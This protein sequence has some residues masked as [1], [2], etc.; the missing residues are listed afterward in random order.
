MNPVVN[1]AIMGKFNPLAGVGNVV[2]WVNHQD[3]PKGPMPRWY[4]RLTPY[5][6]GTFTDNQ[7]PESV[8]EGLLFD[9]VDDR[10]TL[11]TLGRDFTGTRHVFLKILCV[12][13]RVT[14]LL[15]LRNSGLFV[16]DLIGNAN[17]QFDGRIRLVDS[18]EG[19]KTIT[20]GPS[21]GY[22]PGNTLVIHG[23]VS[24][25]GMKLWTNF[26]DDVESLVAIPLA[27]FNEVNIGFL[28]SEPTESPF[29]GFPNHYY[30]EIMVVGG[31]MT[32]EQIQRAR[33]YLTLP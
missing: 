32:E 14:W 13:V 4:S 1:S 10:I 9:G 26:G 29:S 31:D 8:Y 3:V 11:G 23:Q 16:L 24:T 2:C 30:K 18:S 25:T 12:D 7:K 27:P 28:N 6:F 15:Q 21:G 22:F 33:N 20:T 17:D 19:A 5:S